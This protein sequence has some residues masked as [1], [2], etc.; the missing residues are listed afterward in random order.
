MVEELG[1]SDCLGSDEEDSG[2]VI[3]G[4]GCTTFNGVGV[5]TLGVFLFVFSDEGVK[6]RLL[7]GCTIIH[8][9]NVI[10]CV[11]KVDDEC[12]V[13]RFV[14]LVVYNGFS[15]RPSLIIILR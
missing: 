3:I 6:G 4:E 8:L 7:K 10:S 1:G 12:L 15:M 5:V 2:A 9:I 11:N 13:G 14:E